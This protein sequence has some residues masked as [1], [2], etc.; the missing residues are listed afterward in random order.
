MTRAG[1][2]SVRVLLV[3]DDPE[4]VELFRSVAKQDPTVELVGATSPEEAMVLS[5]E[6]PPD[7]IL[8]DH[9][10]PTA[11]MVERSDAATRANRGMTGLEAVE[12]LRSAAPDAVIA[13][14]TA[15]SGLDESVHNSGA[16][17][18]VVKGP[19]PG[20]VL[21]EVSDRARQRRQP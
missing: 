19:D 12:F 1:G 9:N 4:I 13:I 11:N 14:Y 3:D 2:T 6:A 16:D 15:S 17:L 7:A 5:R 10:F 20:A 8:L 18:Y 21:D